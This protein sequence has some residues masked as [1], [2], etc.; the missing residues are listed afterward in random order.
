[1]EH[2]SKNGSKASFVYSIVLFF[3]YNLSKIVAKDTDVD[4]RI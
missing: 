1:M 3:C 4:S 2:F